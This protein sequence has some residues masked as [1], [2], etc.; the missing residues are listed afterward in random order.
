MFYKHSDDHRMI[1]NKAGTE[2]IAYPTASGTVT[3]NGIT[4]IGDGAFSNCT[5]L[6]TA[7]FPEATTIGYR[8]F[9]HCTA[10]TTADF[11]EATS[12]GNSAFGITALTTAYFPE[13]TSI[14]SGAFS[15]CTALTTAYFPEAASIS[16]S[17]FSATGNVALT[18]TLGATPPTL[19][20]TIFEY[21]YSSKT[22]TV[23]VPTGATGYGTLPDTY[24]GSNNAGNW[25][26]A[27]RGKG[28]NGT[29]YL[30]GAVNSNITLTIEGY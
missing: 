26:N 21:V 25:G 1:L 9:Y 15:I 18:V 20:V 13:A 4:G 24:T 27:F 5:A 7:D 22:V 29:N 6:T 11:P 3:L 23:K 8:A 2:L 19:G 14:G 28:W 10:L 16:N 12:I 30:T 17:A